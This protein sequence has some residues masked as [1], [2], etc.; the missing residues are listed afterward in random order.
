MRRTGLPS[1]V[2]YR[3][4]RW[5]RDRVGEPSRLRREEVPVPVEKE[6]CAG[7]TTLLL[8][9]LQV[10]SASHSKRV[11]AFLALSTLVL[12]APASSRALTYG[13]NRVIGSGGVTGFIET[14]GTLGVLTSAN[15]TDWNLSLDDGLST[16]RILGPLSGNNSELIVG[17]S[18]SLVA[19]AS[20]IF[21]DFSDLT[22]N[23]VRFQNP[24]IGS[25]INFW[26]MESPD[27]FCALGGSTESVTAAFPIQIAT[28]VGVV[29]IATVP[30]PSTLALLGLGLAGMAFGARRK[31]VHGSGGTFGNRADDRCVV[32]P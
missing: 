18:G 22:R 10:A 1:L 32:R 16:F 21:F 19:T 28:R 25:G 2:P 30:E 11:L 24:T 9:P 27:G 29:A 20:D 26:C 7:P 6:L 8:N 14:D 5:R 23:V 3:A 4:V 13:V 31:R 17:R 12:I 15:I